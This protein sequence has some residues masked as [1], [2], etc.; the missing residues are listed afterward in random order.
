MN[1]KLLALA[2][3]GAFAAPVAMADTSNVTIYGTI[4]MSRA[5]ITCLGSK[6]PFGLTKWLPVM[7]RRAACA[8]MARPR[9]RPNHVRASEGGN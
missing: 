4:N 1:K 7:P 3:A 6:S 8:F 2:V 5:V 9:G